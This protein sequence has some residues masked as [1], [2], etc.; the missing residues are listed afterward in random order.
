MRTFVGVLLPVLGLLLLMAS[1]VSA[2]DVPALVLID[3]DLHWTVPFY[4]GPVS[5]TGVQEWQN[6]VGYTDPHGGFIEL[7]GRWHVTGVDCFGGQA[8]CAWVD[9]FYSN[10]ANAGLFDLH[11]EGVNATRGVPLIGVPLGPVVQPGDYG[12][13]GTFAVTGIFPIQ[14][15]SAESGHIR[16]VASP[17]LKTLRR[18]MPQHIY[19]HELAAIANPRLQRLTAWGATMILRT[20]QIPATRQGVFITLPSVRLEV[21]EWCSGLVSMKWLLLLAVVVALVIPA[22]LSWKAALVLAA[23]LIALEVNML[24]VAGIGVGVEAWGYAA[25]G[26]L[27]EWLGWAALA[28]GVMQVVGLGWLINRQRPRTA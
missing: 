19:G 1:S 23:P 18:L 4:G 16:V 10:P 8:N 26:P 2:Q 12:F 21:Q 25:S 7:G 3:I 9:N 13:G 22:G 11:L 28:L 6:G 15:F 14:G 5:L 27:K 24:R 17:E 20:L